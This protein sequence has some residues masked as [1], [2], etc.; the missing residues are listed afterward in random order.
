[1]RQRAAPAGWRTCPP[2]PRPGT[3]GPER[4]II[5]GKSRPGRSHSNNVAILFI[6]CLTSY[7]PCVIY[8]GNVKAM[9]ASGIH[10]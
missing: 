1:M 4:D 7:C 5:L 3:P 2:G 9:S 8:N 6:F 10:M